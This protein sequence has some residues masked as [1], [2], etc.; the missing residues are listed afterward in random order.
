MSEPLPLPVPIIIGGVGVSPL[1][2]NTDQDTCVT[3]G[4]DDTIRL[5]AQNNEVLTAT[6]NDVSINAG[7]LETAIE[8]IT[9]DTTFT[10]NQKIIKL[11]LLG[12]DKVFILPPCSLNEGRQYTVARVDSFMAITATIKPTLGEKLNSI[13]DDE[14]ILGPGD[15]VTLQC[16][17]GIDGWFIGL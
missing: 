7:Y 11:D 14:L 15:H 5:I 6:V 1:I 13:I 16:V 3:T 8:V 9:D 17:G 2:C 10:S 4:D 12:A